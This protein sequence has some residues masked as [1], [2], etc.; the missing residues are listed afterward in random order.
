MKLNRLVLLIFS[1]TLLAFL[2]YFSDV[3]GIVETLV[4][5]NIFYVILAFL[6][7]LGAMFSRVFRW[8][9]MLDH[10]NQHTSL[11]NIWKVYV[12][13]AYLST[14]TPA[15]SGDPI[16]AL[17]FK[18]ATGKSFSKALPTLL[19]ERMGDFVASV[20]I[21]LVGLFFL[22]EEM[23]LID[24]FKLAIMVYVVLFSIFLYSFSSTKRL[25]RILGVLKKLFFFVKQLKDPNKINHFSTI[26][27]VSVKQLKDLKLLVKVMIFSFT[28][29]IFEGFIVYFSF[30][31]VGTSV[32]LLTS[33][34]LTQM[35]TL[36][37]VLTF[38]PGSL[39]SF[40]VLLSL[41]MSKLES[42]S[43]STSTAGVL[44]ARTIGLWS[45]VIIGSLL[46]PTFKEKS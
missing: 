3:K 42:L 33:V 7:M 15:R 24:F 39:G 1:F 12:T 36:I 20:S 8:K 22:K 38:L 45:Y 31:S 18:K 4:K 27:S 9:V 16:K 30:L 11:L 17:L 44:I 34:L 2:V 23:F 32:S 43:M 26:A 10:L 25:K 46:L 40:E 41:S 5:A 6:S 29:W 37:S 19:V 28:C 21:A 14:F 13:G 35:V